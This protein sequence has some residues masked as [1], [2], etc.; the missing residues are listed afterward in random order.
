MRD[1]AVNMMHPPPPPPA[2]TRRGGGGEVLT[3][4]EVHTLL[5]FKIAFIEQ[6][7]DKLEWRYARIT[8]SL[9]HDCGNQRIAINTCFSSEY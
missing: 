5:I 4:I 3:D 1:G 2:K 7:T 6:Y 8:A 9:K